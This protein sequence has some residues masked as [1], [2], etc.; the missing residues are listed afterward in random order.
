MK[1]AC[2]INKE[3]KQETAMMAP[4]YGQIRFN[5]LNTEIYINLIFKEVTSFKQEN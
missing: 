3:E 2:S 5:S 4:D 1:G